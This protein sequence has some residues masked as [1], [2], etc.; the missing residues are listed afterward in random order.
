MT[1]VAASSPAHF[2]QK[3]YGGLAIL[4]HWVLAVA[5]AGQVWL[6]WYEQDLPDHSPAQYAALEVHMSI[7]LTILILSLLRLG[8]RL[9]RPAPELP[10]AMPA[11][12]RLLAKATHLLFYVLMLGIPLTGWAL[13]SMGPRP[14]PFWNVID[15]PHLPV[16]GLI[17]ASQRREVHETVESIHG[18]ILV[19]M[20]IGLAALHILG[21]LR[22]QFDRTP[23]LW[24]MIP[25]LKPPSD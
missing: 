22:H 21:A 11:W 4:L 1:S 18:S 13:A 9:A 23:V 20:G 19:W 5:L 15:W 7:G 6:G 17:A 2:A 24:R 25:F 16:G 14:I 12:E 8:L 3:R 10:E